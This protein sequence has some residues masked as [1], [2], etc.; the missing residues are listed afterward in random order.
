M[1]TFCLECHGDLSLSPVYIMQIQPTLLY[2][3]PPTYVP[4]Y[5]IYC[6]DCAHALSQPTRKVEFL[7]GTVN[8]VANQ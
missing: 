1:S 8:P 4:N 7:N 2:T 6:E 5:G 3:D